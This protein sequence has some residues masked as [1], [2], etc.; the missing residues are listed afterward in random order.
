[1]RV[2]LVVFF[3]LKQKITT[4]LIQLGYNMEM[5][6]RGLEILNNN[7]NQLIEKDYNNIYNKLQKKYQNQE[8]IFQIKNKLYKKGYSL[9]EINNYIQKK[10]D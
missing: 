2:F 7:D 4:D 9:D 5:I 8:L 1:M 10:L 6:N 3:I